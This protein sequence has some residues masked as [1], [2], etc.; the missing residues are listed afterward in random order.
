MLLL[1]SN[2][3]IIDIIILKNMFISCRH[4]WSN[5]K[6]CVFYDNNNEKQSRIYFHDSIP[7]VSCGHSEQRQES[8]A[9]VLEVGVFVETLAWMGGRTFCIKIMKVIF[10]SSFTKKKKRF[11][12]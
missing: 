5:N 7:I 9:E 8:H 10:L 2:K 12:L 6:Y 11:G 4:A 1:L 3:I